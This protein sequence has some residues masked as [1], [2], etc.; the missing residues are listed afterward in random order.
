MLY[1]YKY[2]ETRHIQPLF[3]S[4]QTGVKVAGPLTQVHTDM[5]NNGNFLFT[6]F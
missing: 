3:G 1:A 6:P 5:P 2:S 4:A